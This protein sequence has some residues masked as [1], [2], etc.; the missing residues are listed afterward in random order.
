MPNQETAPIAHKDNLIGVCHALGHDFGF[1]P[2]YLR[3]ALAVLLLFSPEAMLI[4][5][6]I[7]GLLVVASRLLVR[8]PRRNAAIVER[9]WVPEIVTSTA[10]PARVPQAMA[11]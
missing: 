10:T 5:Y 9:L 1:N 3:I 8:M 11:A 2:L 4:S 7:A 6:G